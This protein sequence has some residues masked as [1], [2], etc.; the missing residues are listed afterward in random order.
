MQAV[1]DRLF[2]IPERLTIT[3][4][5]GTVTIA[6]AFG[7]TAT[8]KTDNRKQPRLTGEGEFTSKVH[9]EG[10]KLIV[11]DDFSG[12]KVITTYEPVLDGGEIRR[13]KVTV[14]AENMPRGP[15]RGRGGPGGGPGGPPETV[16]FYDVDDKK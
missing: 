8:L 15:G 13:L 6:D 4:G 3:R 12:P 9:Y 14:A 10:A 2:D 11:E 16:R 7:R 5:D 1:R